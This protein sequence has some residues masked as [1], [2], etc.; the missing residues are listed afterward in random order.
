MDYLVAFV[1]HEASLATRAGNITQLPYKRACFLQAMWM[2]CGEALQA[3]LLFPFCW[4]GSYKAKKLFPPFKRNAP[5][6]TSVLV[7][8]LARIRDR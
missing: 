7:L 6:S 1:F 5:R 2:Q 8:M 4:N 3:M